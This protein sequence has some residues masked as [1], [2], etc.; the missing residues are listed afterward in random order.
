MNMEQGETEYFS[1]FPFFLVYLHFKM[2]PDGC[3][4]ELNIKK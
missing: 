3:F 1:S 2:N 4:P